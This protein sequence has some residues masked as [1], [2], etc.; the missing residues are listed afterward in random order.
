MIRSL[1]YDLFG[2]KEEKIVLAQGELLSTYLFHNYLT[3]IGVE[4]TLLPALDF[5]K[6]DENQ[7]PDSSFIE[8][9]LNELLNQYPSNQLFI[10]QG[11]ICRNFM[12][13]VD[14]LRRGGSDYSA[15]LIGA[16]IKA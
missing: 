5:M 3:E 1:S 16:A 12:G 4:S 13:D 7:E 10:T 2:T 9:H 11:Y 6:I 15:S 14:N 8:Q